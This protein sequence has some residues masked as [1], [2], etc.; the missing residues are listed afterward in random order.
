MTLT[1][2]TKLGPY[3]VR[4]SLGVG[5]MGEV[6]RVSDPRLGRDVAVKVLPESLAIDPERLARFKREAQILAALNHPNI[7][8]I[9]GL[10]ENSGHPAL[11]M[12]LVEGSTLAERLAEGPIPLDEALNLAKQIAEALEAAHEK[13]IIHRDL[14]PANIKIAPD[15]VVKVL[16]F[17]LAKALEGETAASEL[18][19]SPTISAMATNMGVILG[20]A[21]YMSPEQAKGK[22]LDRRADIWSFGVVLYEML[23]GKQLFTGETA[24]EVLAHVITKEPAWEALAP[25]PRGIDRLLHQC[26]VKNPKHRLQA[27]GD[28]RLCIEEYFSGKPD[29]D[30][31]P[32]SSKTSRGWKW[33]TL[34]LA[35]TTLLLSFLLL[36]LRTA[37]TNPLL[38]FAFSVPNGE[39]LVLTNNRAVAISPD[40][41]RTAYVAEVEGKIHLWLRNSDDFQ[42]H[43]VPGGENAQGQVFSPDSKWLAFFADGKM[44]KVPANGGPVVG[45][46]DVGDPRGLTWVSDSEIV[47]SPRPTSP[48]F[49][50]SANGGAPRSLT[51]LSA[52][53]LERSHRWPYA[54]PGGKHVLF[55]AGDL[56]NP[57]SYDNANI[58]GVEVAT[59]KRKSLLQ[60]SCV[61]TYMPQGVLIVARAGALY[62]VPFDPERMEV[63]G[64]PVLLL[65][66]VSGDSTTGIAHA[67][68]STGGTLAYVPGEPIV[69]SHVV[70]VDRKGIVTQ[71]DLPI[72]FYRDPR[73]SPDGKKVALVSAQQGGVDVWVYDLEHKTNARLTYAS[74]NLTP[75]WSR[76]GKVIYFT[77]VDNKDGTWGIWTRPADGSQNAELLLKVPSRAL[78]NDISPDGRTLYFSMPSKDTTRYSV[79]RLS[80]QKGAKPESVVDNKF[81]NAAAELSPDGAWLAYISDES[82]RQEI[83]VRDVGSSGARWQVST[84]GGLEPH[85]S[86]NGQELF[87]HWN[88]EMFA[89]PVHTRP[90][91]SFGTPKNIVHSMFELRID[92]FRTF[93]VDPSGKR[94]LTL[95]PAEQSNSQAEVRVIWNWQRDVERL[96]QESK[97]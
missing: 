3:E 5:G 88:S 4:S 84:D 29:V 82:G 33:V 67:T 34:A 22:P 21:A 62:G 46:T 56:A 12:E 7:A 90:V 75:I 57:D 25:C 78:L 51:E 55:T 18:S 40:G 30:P 32:E 86:P 47:F 89:V 63:K 48:L 10:E 49:V 38:K 19:K 28:A 35:G 96:M 8:S 66:H 68:V 76:D 24:S 60:A 64:A 52:E 91:F 36:W 70:W 11:V 61:I 74:T 20:T 81:N 58:E 43:E 2:G 37:P 6:Y 42:A 93:A 27:M 17:G 65:E 23:T 41:M 50:V 1:V 13:G 97:Y 45:I 80:L 94:F 54:L 72:T 71:L 87:Y 39:A 15:G 92:S 69:G 77:E 44:K 85:W 95:R 31:A 79:E 26:L 14:K 83:Y 9:Y 16:D 53:R 73:I 59:G